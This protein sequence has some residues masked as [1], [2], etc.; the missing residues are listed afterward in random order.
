MQFQF[1]PPPSLKNR[2]R[3]VR[4]LGRGGMGLVFQARD[5]MLQ[6]DVAVK[7]LPPERLQNQEASER[8]LREAQTVA[9][10]AHPNI[11]VL[12][13]VGKEGQWHYLVMEFLAGSNLRQLMQQHDGRLP[14]D[15]T[16]QILHRLLD[17][18]AYAHARELVHRDVKPENVMMTTDGRI[19]L[20]DFGLALLPGAARLTQAG[21]LLGTVL[22][23]APECITGA[24][25]THV[26]DLYAMGVLAYELLTGQR[27]FQGESAAR[28][29]IDILNSPIPPL[30]ALQPDIPQHVEQVVLRLLD[31]N[32]QARYPSATA[33][34][35]AL[36]PT[37][38]PAATITPPPPARS[39]AA[40]AAEISRLLRATAVADTSS[41]LE[42]ERKRLSQQLQ[43]RIIAPAQLLLDQAQTYTHSLAHNPNAQM[44][45]SVLSTLTRQLLQEARDLQ[46]QLHP[47][48]LENWGLAA[49]LEALAEQTTRRR[50]VQIQVQ[51][52]RQIELLP[53]PLA[54]AIFRFAQ[55][56]VDNAIQT[57]KATQ[58]N[59][60]LTVTDDAC[61]FR[62]VDNGVV[63]DARAPIAPAQLRLMQLGGNGR[64]DLSP[65]GAMAVEISFELGPKVDLT[66]R[67][68]EVLQWAAAG[69]SNKEIAQK[70]AITP[71]T[72]NFHLDNVYTKLGVRSRTEAAVYALRQGWVTPNPPPDL[73]K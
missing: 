16:L 11:M 58:I 17:A 6:R 42:A 19:K 3:L 15:Q 66:P 20:T 31:K 38:E 62:L 45:V 24:A 43:Q 71:R 37:P 47:T 69:L 30:R 63:P 32:P 70:L 23:L 52:A 9:Q 1:G 55:S 21:A 44:A 5:E 35:A 53:P 68:L 56:A 27:P 54:L 14:L 51:A 57:A 18:L 36:T 73:Y 65:S 26:S 2:Y 41:A 29:M 10:L 46:S 67:E 4:Q 50:G 60:S 48:I 34:Q 61:T 59:I 22:Y 7:F 40:D 13:D 72:V 8:F 33:V 64:L 49:A 28:M 12:F 39:S 25:A